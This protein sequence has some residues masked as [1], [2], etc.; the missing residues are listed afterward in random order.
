MITCDN[1]EDMSQIFPVAVWNEYFASFEVSLLSCHLFVFF[2][3]SFLKVLVTME[4]K[5]ISLIDIGV[6]LGVVK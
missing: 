6:I 3:S 2:Y 5:Y 4:T 1:L